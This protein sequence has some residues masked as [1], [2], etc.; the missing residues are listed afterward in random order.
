MHQIEAESVV[1]ECRASRM[2]G[3]N[4]ADTAMRRLFLVNFVGRPKRSGMQKQR[5]STLAKA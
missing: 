1:S 4:F 3:F 5:H 2:P